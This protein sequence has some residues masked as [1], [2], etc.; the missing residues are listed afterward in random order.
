MFVRFIYWVLIIYLAYVVWKFIRG[1]KKR[2][3]RPRETKSLP[4]M[5]VHDETCNTYLPVEEA[6]KEIY[7]GREYYFCSKECRQKFLDR[8]RSGA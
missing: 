7:E 4:H 1:P 8:K 2:A 6:I 5:M 3:E